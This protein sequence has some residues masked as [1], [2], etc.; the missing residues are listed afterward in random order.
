M[1]FREQ[2]EYYLLE[3]TQDTSKKLITEKNNLQIELALLWQNYR[4]KCRELFL[5]FQNEKQKLM[6][7]HNQKIQNLQIQ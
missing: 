2:V 7:R 5:W 4:K 1:K 6:I 3:A